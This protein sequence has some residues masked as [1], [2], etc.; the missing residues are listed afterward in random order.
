MGPTRP[1][2]HRRALARVGHRDPAQDDTRGIES[3][4]GGVIPE[5]VTTHAPLITLNQTAGTAI[6]LGAGPAGLA[7]GL[8]LSRAG[9]QLHAYERA[10]VVGGLARTIRHSGCGFDIGGHRWFTKKVE[11]NI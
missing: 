11:L 2:V 4:R 3:A 5:E 6:V 10:N 9:W 8:A 1:Q 7:A